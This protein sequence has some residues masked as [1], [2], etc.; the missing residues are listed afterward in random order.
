MFNFYNYKGKLLFSDIKYQELDEITE[1][2]AA[3]F[4]G[5]S[6]FLNNN[7]P[8]QSRRCFCVS[9]PSLLFLNH[10]D[11]G[12]ISISDKDFST[13][14]PH[15]IIDK[16]KMREIMSLNTSYPSWTN[17]LLNPHPKIWKIH[18]VGTGDVGGILATGIRLLGGGNVS[19][20]GLY[21]NDKNS[22]KR[23]EYEINQILPPLSDDSYP[24]ISIVLEEDL[25]DCDM[26]VFC[27]SKGIPPIGQ[28][29][30]DVRLIQLEGNS[31]IIS[32]YAK[33]ARERGFNGI[34]AVV[35][36]PVDL[37]CKTAWKSSNQ[38]YKGKLDFKGLAPEQIRG[39]GLGVMHARAAYYAQQ[40]KE[41]AHYLTEGRAFGPH[42]EGLVI[43]DSI[44]RYNE[45]LSDYLTEKAKKA[46]IEIRKTGY[47]PYI[48]PALS[49]GTL[50][51]LATIKGQWHYSSTYMGGVYMGTRNRLIESGTEL[52]QFKLPYSLLDK[53]KHSYEEL[54][55]FSG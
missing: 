36:D 30:E 6:Y 45:D 52:E 4:N 19:T 46:N 20:I 24:Q 47:K 16:I 39:Y 54:N 8:S 40:R 48:A 17:I 7:P 38:D 49:S 31:E 37:L 33:H 11:L 2:E 51:I 27:A 32:I 26:F 53:L 55:K 44:E 35:S 43:A 5:L 13:I 23:W 21:G 1:K 14:V 22:V 41:T 34:F 50:S 3:N 12:L 15:W 28:N 29:T 42:G 9:H 10:E 18:I 25:F